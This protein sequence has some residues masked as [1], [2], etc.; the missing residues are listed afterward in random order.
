MVV[1]PVIGRSVTP[2]VTSTPLSPLRSALTPDN[3]VARSPRSTIPFSVES[4][5][6]TSCSR[7]P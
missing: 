7:T 6:V 5:A 3:T 2:P 1:I 4:P